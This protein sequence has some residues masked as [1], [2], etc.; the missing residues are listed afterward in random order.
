MRKPR[1]TSTAYSLR[2]STGSEE[3]DSFPAADRVQMLSE[4]WTGIIGARR[5]WTVSMIS[6]LSMPSR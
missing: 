4:L 5:T 2:T 1:R 6:V 3:A